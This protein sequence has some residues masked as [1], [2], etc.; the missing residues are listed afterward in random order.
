[1]LPFT[2]GVLVLEIGQAL[3][4]PER[5]TRIIAL[6]VVMLLMAVGIYALNWRAAVRI[7]QRIDR[8]KENQ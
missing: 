8:L 2:P 7:Q 5:T 1:L 4:R 3:A 6:S